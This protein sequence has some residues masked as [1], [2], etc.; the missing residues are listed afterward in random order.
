LPHVVVV[1]DHRNTREAL[2]I[3]L[4]AL[5]CAATAVASADEALALADAGRVDACVCD[6]GW[7]GTAGL[8]LARALR[9]RHPGIRLV[10]MTAGEVGPADRQ[11]AAALGVPLLIKPVDAETVARVL[12]GADLRPALEEP[13]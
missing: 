6:L 2:A 5:D 12:F 8:D 1:D 7:P 3:G 13:R 11:R 4:R 10:L 9:R